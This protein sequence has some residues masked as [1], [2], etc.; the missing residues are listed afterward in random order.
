[1]NDVDDVTAVVEID[2]DDVGLAAPRRSIA[3]RTN[4]YS[5]ARPEIELR[6]TGWTLGESSRS[7]VAVNSSIRTTA[8]LG[9][10]STTLWFRASVSRLP[11]DQTQASA[12]QAGSTSLSVPSISC[13]RRSR[14]ACRRVLAARR[15]RLIRQVY[16]TYVIEH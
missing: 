6:P 13:H 14:Q 3:G 7:C 15:D 5:S 8:A 10:T 9:D 4:P 16:I 1:M 11:F 2:R 12:I